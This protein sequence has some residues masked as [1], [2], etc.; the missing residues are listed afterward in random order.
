MKKVSE[1]VT[2]EE[3]CSVRKDSQCNGPVAGMCPISLNIAEATVATEEWTRRWTEKKQGSDPLGTFGHSKD[4]Y[5][6]SG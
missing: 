2:G 5:I 4:M 1:G 6:Q 3:E